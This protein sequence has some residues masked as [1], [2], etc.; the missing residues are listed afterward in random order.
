MEYGDLVPSM[1]V[2]A[3]DPRRGFRAPHLGGPPRDNI[4]GHDAGLR[5]I[6]RSPVPTST[7]FGASESSHRGMWSR[8]SSPSSS[9]VHWWERLLHNQSGLRLK[10]RLLFQPAVMVTSIPYQL[11]SSDQDTAASTAPAG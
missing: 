1:K 8:F 4:R 3:H 5:L 10:S 9:S 7:T 6:G 2:K 11:Q